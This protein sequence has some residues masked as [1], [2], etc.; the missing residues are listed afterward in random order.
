MQ[1]SHC[2][3]KALVGF[4]RI[5]DG[6]RVGCP[7]RVGRVVV[8]V[9][10]LVPQGRPPKE[11][12]GGEIRGRPKVQKGVC[13]PVVA[14]GVEGEPPELVL[15]LAPQYHSLVALNSM[16]SASC[17]GVIG[18]TDFRVEIALFVIIVYIIVVRLSP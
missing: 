1:P 15:P 9:I 3:L 10:L 8:V 5:W 11:A 17:G 7:L 2:V 13:L 14:L 4:Q 6:F 18:E 12:G 16:I